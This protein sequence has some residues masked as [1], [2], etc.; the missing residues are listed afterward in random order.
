MSQDSGEMGESITHVRIRVT[1]RHYIG[2]HLPYPSQTTNQEVKDSSHDDNVV[3]Y[4]D[5]D[6]DNG[7]GDD[8]DDGDDDEDDYDDVHT[9]QLP[10]PQSR[11]AV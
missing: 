6:D 5:E 8:D 10:A 7:D 11:G 2:P 9:A 1:W 3:D 4:D